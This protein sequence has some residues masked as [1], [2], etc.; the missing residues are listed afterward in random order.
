MKTAEEIVREHGERMAGRLKADPVHEARIRSQVER[1]WDSLPPE[2]KAEIE[3]RIQ[4]AGS[5][6]GST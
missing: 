3:R 2:R 5:E 1:W 6:E 4:E